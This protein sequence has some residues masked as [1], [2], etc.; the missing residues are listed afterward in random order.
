MKNEKLKL[1]WVHGWESTERVCAFL[2]EIDFEMMPS[3]SERVELHEYAKKL[4]GYADN[5]FIVKDGVDVASCS[6]YCNTENAFISSIAVKA[7]YRKQHIGTFMLREVKA[8]IKK[9]HCVKL[10]LNVYI[11]ND[12]AIQFYENNG[13]SYKEQQGQWIMMEFQC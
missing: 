6:V 9:H 3:L 2:K 12:V 10:C 1:E 7:A 8:H 5:L 4:S 13:F 11:N